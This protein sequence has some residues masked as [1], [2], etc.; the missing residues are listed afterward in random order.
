[1][2]SSIAS[3]QQEV[4]PDGVNGDVTVSLSVSVPEVETKAIADGTNVDILYYEVYNSDMSKKL[5]TGTTGRESEKTFKLDLTL[6]QDQ[7]Y[8]FLFW[9][10][11]DKD[12]EGNQ[13]NYYDVSDLTAVT[14]NYDK[15]NGCKFVGNVEDRAAFYA[16]ETFTIG[17]NTLKETIYLVRPFA[18]LNFG[19]TTFESSMDQNVTVDGSV[20]TVTNASTKF[21]VAS[22]VGSAA[23]EDIVTIEFTAEGRPTDPATLTLDDD[24]EYEYLSMNYFFVAGKEATSTVSA[25]FKTSVGDVKHNISSVPIAQN[26]R[27]NI[28]GDLLFNKTDFVI[29]VDDRFAKPDKDVFYVTDA[30]SLT[31]AISKMNKGGEVRLQEDVVV[32]TGLVVPDKVV[33]NGDGKKISAPEQPTDNGIIRPAGNV[34]VKNLTIDAKAEKTVDGK[35]LRAIYITKGGNYVLDN[36]VTDGTTYAINV[37]TTQNV[38]LQVENTVLEGWT[39]YGSTTTAT[40]ENVKFTCGLQ[41]Y[42]RPYGTTVLTGCEFEEGF[43]VDYSELAKNGKTIKFIDCKYGEE[44]LTAANIENFA[45]NFDA[46]V[47]SFE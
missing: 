47:V 24:S 9:A 10:Q 19:T 46:S 8:N 45:E 27:T 31:E 41:A 15:A 43:T 2:V 36:V 35:G 40:F 25:V 42:F 23:D 3:C 6:V 16:A 12:A 26:Y 14:I 30:A 7:T 13:N 32:P 29:K 22:K 4:I 28:V 21:D 20:I 34:T 39:S 11:V 33:L 1:M 44:P 5:V 18:Q 37:N 17:K 38:T